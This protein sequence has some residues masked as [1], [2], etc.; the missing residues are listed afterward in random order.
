MQRSLC[1]SGAVAGT[2]VTDNVNLM[3]DFRERRI[4]LT[5]VEGEW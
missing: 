4:G 5:I 1:V 2:S 3:L